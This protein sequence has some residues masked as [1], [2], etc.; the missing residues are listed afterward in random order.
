MV[1]EHI[2]KIIDEAKYI[3]IS[4]HTNPDGDAIG[5]MVAMG[6]FCQNKGVDYTLLL[7]KPTPLMDFFEGEINV[8]Y[9]TEVLPIIDCFIGLDC[10]NV[11]RLVGYKEYFKK[12]GT[13]ICIDHHQTSESYA[14]QNY[15]QPEAS[16]TSELV[17]EYI[18]GTGQPLDEVI[19][20]ALY[21][22]IVTDTGGFM[23]Q[24]TSARTHEI[25]AQ[26]M[27]YSFD[28]STLYYKVLKETTYETIKLQGIV[29]TRLEKLTDTGVY[30]SYLTQEDI[31]AVHA[32]KDDLSSLVSF[33]KNIQGVECIAF[34]YPL[35]TQTY[36]LSMRANPPYNVAAFC[37]Q[38]GGGGHQLASGASLNGDL[39]TVINR[40]KKAIDAW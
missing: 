29:S 31:E 13:S 19:A 2:T 11:D 14:T 36:K 27:Q 24:C 17:Y 20:K 18:T 3:G 32:T 1:F 34:V 25:T 10:G 26:L 6:R 7:E 35:Q 8:S 4:A 21:M 28:F 5:A 12:V 37:E 22:G 38:F 30:F 23:H 33:L 9:T 16:S 15:I 40:L 39:E